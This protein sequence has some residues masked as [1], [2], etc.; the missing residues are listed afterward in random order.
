MSIPNP[1]QGLLSDLEPRVSRSDVLELRQG[2]LS[3]R[4]QQRHLQGRDSHVRTAARHFLGLMTE[5]DIKRHCTYLT[6]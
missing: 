6:Q 5:N 4:P 2:L 3:H 1:S